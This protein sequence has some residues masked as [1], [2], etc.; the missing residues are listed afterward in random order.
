MNQKELYKRKYQAQLDEWKADVAKLKAKASGAGAEARIEMNKLIKELDHRID[1]AGTELSK[2]ATASE[3]AWD[4][5]RK[6]VE[7]AW[8]SLMSA[9]HDAASKFKG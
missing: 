1:E 3:E 2:L 4:S 6:G 7:S 9:V 8:D 5:A